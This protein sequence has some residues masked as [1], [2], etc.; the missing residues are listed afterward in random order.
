MVKGGFNQQFLLGFSKN[1]GDFSTDF[2]NQHWDLDDF[3]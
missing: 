2:H 1:L 3:N